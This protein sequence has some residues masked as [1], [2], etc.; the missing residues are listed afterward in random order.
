MVTRK[1]AEKEP[2]HPGSL[3][4]SFRKSLK[5]NLEREAYSR[6]AAESKGLHAQSLRESPP[7][8][9][10]ALEKPLDYG[11]YKDSEFY[12]ASIP[13][14]VLFDTVQ[15]HRDRRWL[16][17][18][19]GNWTCQYCGEKIQIA[20]TDKE[21]KFVCYPCACDIDFGKVKP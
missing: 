18:E 5:E 17:I 7:T 4:A 16:H 12:T 11:K 15:K 6:K 1:A 20:T 10:A 9:S 14:K 19:T 21:H 8:K 2:Y 13:R 3:R